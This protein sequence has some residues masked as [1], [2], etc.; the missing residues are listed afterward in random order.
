M[1]HSRASL[2]SVGVHLTFSS[3]HHVPSTALPIHFFSHFGCR[4]Y[5]SAT[6]H[7]EQ[8]NHRKFRVWNSHGHERGHVTVAIP[9]AAFSAVR[10]CGY[11]VGPKQ[12]D[13]PSQ[14]QLR[15]LFP[16]AAFSYRL[17]FLI[18]ADPSLPAANPS[19]GC[20]HLWHH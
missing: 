4:M 18:T 12:C 11:T 19:A 5:R 3:Y 6:T 20:A 14:R 16:L 10:L 17:T 1:I 13:R 7:S 9:D 8:P 15:F 2:R